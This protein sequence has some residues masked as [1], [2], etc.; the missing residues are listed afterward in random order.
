MSEILSIFLEE[1]IFIVL[2]TSNISIYGC[3]EKCKDNQSS[4]IQYEKFINCL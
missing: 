4:K 1:V 3:I 2:Y